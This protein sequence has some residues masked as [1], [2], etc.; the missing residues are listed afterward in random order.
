MKKK[1]VYISSQLI[2]TPPQEYAPTKTK[3][4]AREGVV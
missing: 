1:K 3:I 2:K 4:S